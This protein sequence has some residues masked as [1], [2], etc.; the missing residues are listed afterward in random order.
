M[1]E[2]Y[3][4]LFHLPGSFKTVSVELRIRFGSFRNLSPKTLRDHNVF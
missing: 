1:I 3:R 4:S 2:S